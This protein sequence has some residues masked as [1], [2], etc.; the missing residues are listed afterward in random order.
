[1]IILPYMGT[2]GT[3]YM[4]LLIV[5]LIVGLGLLAKKLLLGPILDFGTKNTH[6]HRG[7]QI[8]FN[9]WLKLALVSFV[10]IIISGFALGLISSGSPGGSSH[11]HGGMPNNIPTSSNTPNV[12]NASQ[13]QINML[14][15][16]M[17][18]MEMRMNSI[19][20]K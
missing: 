12:S 9:K 5:I 10:G 11:A 15:Q 2:V 18:Q 8:M 20:Y 13:A 19:L 4:G 1:M 16:R 17:N 3:I 6:K 14:M 7:G